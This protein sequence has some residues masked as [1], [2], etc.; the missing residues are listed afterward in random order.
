[1]LSKRDEYVTEFMSDALKTVLRLFDTSLPGKLLE[2]SV[3]RTD[4]ADSVIVKF[5]ADERPGTVFSY[6]FGVFDAG[7][8]PVRGAKLD[9]SVFLGAIMERTHRWSP[10]KG[11]PSTGLVHL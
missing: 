6:E 9:V 10:R 2:F 5:T 4:A 7:A 1:M 11:E 8:E 3:N